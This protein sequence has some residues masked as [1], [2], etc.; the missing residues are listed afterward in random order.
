[1]SRVQALVP[2]PG[3]SRWR[4][5][6]QLPEKGKGP[7]SSPPVGKRALSRVTPSA[8]AQTCPA[9][10]WARV[11]SCARALSPH[12]AAEEMGADR[13]ERRGRRR[14]GSFPLQPSVKVFSYWFVQGRTPQGREGV[15]L[16][17]LQDTPQWLCFLT[18]LGGF[19][20]TTPRPPIPVP[21]GLVV[22]WGTGASGPSLGRALPGPFVR[23][24]RDEGPPDPGQA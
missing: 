2:F 15:K 20:L 13:V 5:A 19:I 4:F 3:L 17:A 11:L 23:Q 6:S 18:C 21:Q 1:M 24:P 7:S 16:G 22:K 12:Q 10:P 9:L 14:R 8:T